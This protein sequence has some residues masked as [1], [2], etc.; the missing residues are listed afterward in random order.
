[1]LQQLSIRTRLLFLSGILIA[2]IA[3]ATYYL[4]T[5][6]V[7]NSRA[8]ARNVELAVLIDVAQDVRNNFGQYRYWTTDLA[9]SLLRQSELNAHAARERLLHRLDDLARGRPDVAAALRET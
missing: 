8:V 7:E 1:M 2:M 3:G 5:K 6:L 9:V 4:I